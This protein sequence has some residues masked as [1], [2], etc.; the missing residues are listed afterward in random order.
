[1]EVQLIASGYEPAQAAESK[2]EAPERKT[3]IMYTK[4]DNVGVLHVSGIMYYEYYPEIYN[5]AR[6]AVED[7][8]IT[9]LILSWN[10]PGGDV[11]GLHNLAERLFELRQRKKI[12]SYVNTQCMSAGVWAAAGASGGEIYASSPTDEVGSIGAMFQHMDVSARNAAL[13]LKITDIT[14]GKYKGITTSNRP[15]TE[16]GEKVIQAKVGGIYEIFLTSLE[17]FFGYSRDAVLTM[18]EGQ[19]F[20]ARTAKAVGLVR[21]IYE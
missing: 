7:A 8:G 11:P 15:L 14:A 21:G 5:K 4:L 19:V 9:A 17:K 13:G 16:E 1:M 2:P 10:T 12:V 6:A 18:S 20:L 3:H